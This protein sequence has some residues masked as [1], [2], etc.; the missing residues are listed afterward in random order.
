M[1]EYVQSIHRYACRYSHRQPYQSLQTAGISETQPET[2]AS[3]GQHE[4]GA[5]KG[6][7]TWQ[8]DVNV[9]EKQTVLS[10]LHQEEDATHAHH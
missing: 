1:V 5:A 2:E 10:V 3:N 7:D 8:S 6:K 9:R 4:C